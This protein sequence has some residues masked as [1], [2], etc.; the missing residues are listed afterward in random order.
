MVL[1]PGL[2]AGLCLQVGLL[3]G[4][5]NCLC[6]TSIEECI[7]WLGGPAV[8]NLYLA[9]PCDGLQGQVRSLELLPGHLGCTELQV[10][11]CRYL[12]M[13]LALGLRHASADCWDLVEELPSSWS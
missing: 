10:M 3:V 8:W 2:L 5:C 12:W 4:L 11:L 13:C 1:L 6:M 7:L 9:G